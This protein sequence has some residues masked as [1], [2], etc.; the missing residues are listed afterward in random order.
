MNECWCRRL[1]AMAGR[2]EGGASF[3]GAC[4]YHKHSNCG[5]SAPAISA[6]CHCMLALLPWYL[7]AAGCCRQSRPTNGTCTPYLSARSAPPSIHADLPSFFTRCPC[8]AASFNPHCR[9]CKPSPLQNNSLD[10][11]EIY[12]GPYNTT[13]TEN[14]SHH[15]S[16]G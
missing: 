11:S 9:T 5:V 15:L 10:G 8:C 16:S 7:L 1:R 13:A 3:A 6:I 4:R 2:W 14:L 12:L